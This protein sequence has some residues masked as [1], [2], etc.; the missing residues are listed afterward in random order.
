MPSV[1][2][3]IEIAIDMLAASYA[4]T[5][6]RLDFRRYSSITTRKAGAVFDTFTKVSYTI[7]RGSIALGQMMI[8]RQ[9]D[10]K[11]FASEQSVVQVG[12]MRFWPQECHVHLAAVAEIAGYVA[13]YPDRVD[14]IEMRPT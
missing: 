7:S 10:D 12:W 3:T 13:F 2:V 1:E 14:A 4:V 11:Q 9:D 6:S 5:I 8:A